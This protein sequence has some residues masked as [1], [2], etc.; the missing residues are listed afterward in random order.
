ML[1]QDC[2]GLAFKDKEAVG[3]QADGVAL[4]PAEEST[5]L[6]CLSYILGLPPILPCC[7]GCIDCALDIQLRPGATELPAPALLVCTA[8]VPA[9]VAAAEA[10]A[11]SAAEASA[12]AAAGA[13]ATAAAAAAPATAAAAAAPANSTAWLQGGVPTGRWGSH[14]HVVCSDCRGKCCA[15]HGPNCCL[16]RAGCSRTP[17]FWLDMHRDAHFEC[18][19]SQAWPLLPANSWTVLTCCSPTPA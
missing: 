16:V 17:C 9:A 8:A 15:N 2:L 18:T 7:A 19:R 4:T 6:A 3:A 13:P 1:I 12:A 5:E 14:A 11:L 10:P